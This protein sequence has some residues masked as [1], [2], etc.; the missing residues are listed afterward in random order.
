YALQFNVGANV[1]VGDLNGDGYA[2]VITGATVGNP[3]VRVYS[4]KDITNG[5]FNPDGSSLLAQFFAYGI[6]FN[7][8][9]YV[10]TGDVNGDGF[11]DLLTG[12][13]VGNPDVRVYNGRSFANGTFN[14]NNL[15]A[16]LL[17][18]FFA[19]DLQ[20]NIGVALATGDVDGDG[21]KDIITG[22][23]AGSPHLRVVK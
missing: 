5:P 11:V 8:G 16:S 3:D 4:G 15:D 18:Q 6:N 20:F 23:S 14:N 22:A 17:T 7:V 21:I 12:A 19:Y 13:S 2:D 1:A 9:A 10:A